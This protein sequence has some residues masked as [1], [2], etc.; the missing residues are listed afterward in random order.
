MGWD[1]NPRNALTFAGFQDHGLGLGVVTEAP[2]IWFLKSWESWKLSGG[3]G[4]AFSQP[5][6]IHDYGF[7][8]FLL[9]KDFGKTF[10]L[11]GELYAQGTIGEGIRSA[12]IFTFGGNYNFTENFALLFSTGHSIAG[13]DTFMG[14]IG[15]D[16]TFGL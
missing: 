5:H 16:W 15:L 9:Q 2:A 1:S 14:Y 12:L 11:G 6:F 8:G 10:T 3:G 7:G 13:Q 4:Y